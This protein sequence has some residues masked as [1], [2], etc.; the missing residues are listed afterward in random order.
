MVKV[1]VDPSFKFMLDGKEATVADLQ[2]GTRL[3]RTAF[4][5]VESVSYEGE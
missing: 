5:V 4:R 2:P 3:T 1:N